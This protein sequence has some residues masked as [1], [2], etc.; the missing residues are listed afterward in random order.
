MSVVEP[1]PICPHCGA[2]FC[3]MFALFLHLKRCQ[4]IIGKTEP[5]EE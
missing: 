2:E 1:E 4:A 3:N 5:E